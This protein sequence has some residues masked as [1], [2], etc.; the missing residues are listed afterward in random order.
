MQ[1]MQ[2][3]Y[4][5]PVQEEEDNTY[6]ALKGSPPQVDFYGFCITKMIH[7]QDIV[8]HNASLNF[9]EAQE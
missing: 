8:I 5:F 3:K 6:T 7:N 1:K 2:N 4:K 9:Q